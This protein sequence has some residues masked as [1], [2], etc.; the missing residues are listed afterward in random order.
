[1]KTRSASEERAKV[2]NPSVDEEPEG[3]N[4]NDD[5]ADTQCSL[6]GWR[7]AWLQRFATAKFFAIN[8]SI[9][10]ILQGAM[11]TYTVREAPLTFDL[12]DS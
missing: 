4:D 12:N 11:F 1:M 2:P 10:G 6:F 3:D 7:P 9:V 5:I 8:F